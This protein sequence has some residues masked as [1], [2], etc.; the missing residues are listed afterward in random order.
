MGETRS[1]HERCEA[2]RAGP[3][4]LFNDLRHEVQPVLHGGRGTLEF[5]ALHH[6]RHGVLT[7]TQ[8]H[9]FDLFDGM[10]E[11]C[12]ACGVDGLHLLDK[13][14]KIIELGKRVFSF[15]VGQFEPRKMRDAF[16][17]GQGQSHAVTGK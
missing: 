7:Q 2:L 1:P 9:I 4:C 16:N 3:G 15:S 11:R 14:K 12:D 6:F 17:I 10:G 13:A 5:V 8:C